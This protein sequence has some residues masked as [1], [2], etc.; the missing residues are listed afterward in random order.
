VEVQ[1]E[2]FALAMGAFHWGFSKVREQKFRT[3]CCYVADLVDRPPTFCPSEFH[4]GVALFL[5]PSFLVSEH[6]SVFVVVV[7]PV[8][9][10]EE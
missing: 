2:E 10:R 3:H 7:E 9:A 5:D 8:D 6:G 1:K 4:R